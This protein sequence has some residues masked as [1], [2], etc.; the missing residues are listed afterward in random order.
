MGLSR[1]LEVIQ[2]LVGRLNKLYKLFPGLSVSEGPKVEQSGRVPFEFD[3]RTFF[4]FLFTLG[5]AAT[6]AST[7][8]GCSETSL[9]V[10]SRDRELSHVVEPF[11]GLQ[12]KAIPLED[13][14][15]FKLGIIDSKNNFH[16]IVWN[17]GTD[18]IPLGSDPVKVREWLNKHAPEG[19]KERLRNVPDNQILIIRYLLYLFHE[20]RFK[21]VTHRSLQKPDIDWDKRSVEGWITFQMFRALY[22]NERGISPEAAG[23]IERLYLDFGLAPYPWGTELDTI[24]E[25]LCRS[26]CG[27]SYRFE[28]YQPIQ[29]TEVSLVSDGTQIRFRGGDSEALV[30]NCDVKLPGGGD[31]KLADFLNSAP[32]REGWYIDGKGRVYSA[33]AVGLIKKVRLGADSP[34]LLVIYYDEGNNLKV[35]MVSLSDIVAGKVGFVS[36]R[37]IQSLYQGRP[38][39]VSSSGI[40][41]GGERM[42]KNLVSILAYYF[43]LATGGYLRKSGQDLAREL[44]QAAK[45]YGGSMAQ[46][47]EQALREVPITSTREVLEARV[48]S[49][50]EAVLSGL[51]S[52]A[53]G[54]ITVARQEIPEVL[55]EEGLVARLRGSNGEVADWPLKGT[56]EWVGPSEL[57]VKFESKN[58]EPVAEFSLGNQ[59][60]QIEGWDDVFSLITQLIPAHFENFE[61]RDVADV[62]LAAIG[63]SLLFM[64]AKEPGLLG[65]LQIERLVSKA[66]LRTG[67]LSGRIARLAAGAVAALLSRL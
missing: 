35:Q 11:G 10:S 45:S 2:R 9:P 30:E 21:T 67:K 27:R 66:I 52:P 48:R 38:V 60:Y 22:E 46:T 6:V 42:F 47:I 55:G 13:G 25:R 31:G 49:F 15:S 37:V 64:V 50:I 23:V 33:F 59:D 29:L 56:M 51:I 17:Q 43:L 7:S 20:L 44:Q 58:G 16:E 62:V 61:S 34:H 32:G 39:E 19:T 36:R 1:S 28:N 41:V 4:K 40:P 57:S 18:P 63:F 53:D 3:R 54:R 65:D 5:G 26:F 8:A 24:V 14:I 12:V